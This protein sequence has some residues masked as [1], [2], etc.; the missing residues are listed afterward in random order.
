MPNLGVKTKLALLA[1]VAVTVV[2]LS[3]AGGAYAS[4]SS[5]SQPVMV[6]SQ[7]AVYEQTTLPN[8][9]LNFYPAAHATTLPNDGGVQFA[10]PDATGSS[11]TF[12]NYLL[13][14]FTANLSEANVLTATINV[15][16][17]SGSTAFLG[18]TFGGYNLPTPSFVRLFI[19]ANLPSNG[20]AGCVGGN[21]NIDNYWW[22]DPSFGSYTFVNGGSTSTTMLQVPLNPADWSGICGN[23]ATL[24]TTAFD[25]AISDIKYVGLSFGSGYFYASGVG[26]DGGTGTANFQL[27][28]YTIS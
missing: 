5:I 2:M 4:S 23:P 19:Q 26:V 1:T 14:T 22:A 6:G 3:S 17:S 9:G 25:S 21:S 11:P 27:E 20:S 8:G 13:D 16:A 15:V 10:M 24:N 28:S 18:D 7:W 12:V